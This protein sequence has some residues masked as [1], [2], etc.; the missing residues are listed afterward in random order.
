MQHFLMIKDLKA[1]FNLNVATS[2]NMYSVFI[3]LRSLIISYSV[4]ITEI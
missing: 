4:Y 3:Y 2:G 1:K